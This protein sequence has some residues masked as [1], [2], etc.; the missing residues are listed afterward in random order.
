M[1]RTIAIVVA[2]QSGIDGGHRSTLSYRVFALNPMICNNDVD[3]HPASR[4]PATCRS[5]D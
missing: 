5:A 3:R 2:I 4:R 1:V